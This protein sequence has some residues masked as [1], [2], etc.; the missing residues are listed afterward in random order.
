M[1]HQRNIFPQRYR[2]P[3]GSVHQQRNVE[4]AHEQAWPGTL[5][6]FGIFVLL[7]SFW[8]AGIRTLEPMAIVGRWLALFCFVGNLLPYKRFGLGL[9][10]ERL[11]W[12]LFNL[13]AVGP[14]VFSAMLWLN[15]FV[16]G[17]EQLRI[18]QYNGDVRE[19]HTYW[20][21]TGAMPPIYQ[22][23]IDPEKPRA[24]Q[25][26]ERLLGTATGL[27]GYEVVSTWKRHDGWSD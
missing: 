23:V 25:Y 15:L 16:H 12:F 20:S 26:G 10:M 11:E 2:P 5:M 13:L 21:E 27:F 4:G 22:D 9:G 19:L 17:P 24:L 14:F 18:V 8:W 6:V 1:P 3:T 7:F